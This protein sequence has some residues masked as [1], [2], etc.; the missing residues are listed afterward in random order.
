M[1]NNM[2]TTE[3]EF[4][5]DFIGDQTSLSSTEEKALS[6]Y[7]KQKKV[8]LKTEEIKKPLRKTKLKTVTK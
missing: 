7:F 6:D 1:T 2:K 4:D 3:K 8:S 5:I